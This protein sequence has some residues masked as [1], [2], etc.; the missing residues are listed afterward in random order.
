MVD[1]HRRVEPRGIIGSGMATDPDRIRDLGIRVS[2]QE[3][4]DK[5]KPKRSF[6]SALEEEPQKRTE[7]TE[8]ELEGASADEKR[9]AKPRLPK[10]IQVSEDQF[11]NGRSGF[12]RDYFCG[13]PTSSFNA[14][15][16]LS[17]TNFSACFPKKP[18]S[19]RC[20]KIP[21]CASSGIVK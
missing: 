18:S 7:D 1:E 11:F 2:A 9:E 8:L 15:S 6:A 3:R 14:L 16:A 10:Q 5:G 4:T 13:R 17:A 12:G 21:N 20:F 19:L